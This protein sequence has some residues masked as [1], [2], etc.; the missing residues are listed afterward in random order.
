MGS[1]VA[2]TL[3]SPEARAKMLADLRAQRLLALNSGE[4]S[5]RFRMPLVVTESEIDM[6][7]TKVAAC[8]PSRRTQVA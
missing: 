8:L 7:L 1:L 5:I 3:E 2:F 4:K 6:A